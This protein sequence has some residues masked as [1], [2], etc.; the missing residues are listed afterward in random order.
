MGNITRL[1]R[2]IITVII[3]RVVVDILAVAAVA[4]VA[5]VTAVVVMAAEVIVVEED[6][7]VEEDMEE[8]GTIPEKESMWRMGIGQG[9]IL[10]FVSRSV[11]ERRKRFV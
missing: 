11:R 5:V 6:T 2:I 7:R 10:T 1:L 3:A 9:S 8:E 4:T